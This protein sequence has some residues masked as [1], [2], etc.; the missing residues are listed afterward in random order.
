M[1]ILQKL[2]TKEELSRTGVLGLNDE[3]FSLYVNALLEEEKKDILIVTSTLYEANKLNNYLSN[4]TKDSYLFPMDEFF[5]SESEAHSPD[6]KITRLETLNRTFDDLPKI[7]VTHLNGYLRFLPKKDVYKRSILRIKKGDSF[8]RDDLSSKLFNLGY[9][10]ETLVTKTGEV[11]IRGFVI[12]IFPLEYNSPI[13]IEFFG[14]EIDSIRTFDEESQKSIEELE[15]VIIYPNTE[16]ILENSDKDYS[17]YK[18]KYLR[19]ESGKKVD[20]IY[21]YLKDPIVIFKDYVQIESNYKMLFEQIIEYKYNKDTDYDDNYMFY[22]EDINYKEYK[23]YNTID[24]IFR[25]KNIDYVNFNIEEISSF[26]E[27]IELINDYLK[28]KLIEEKTII[29]ALK[30]HQAMNFVKYLEVNYI[31]TDVTKIVE[32]KINI[33]K[34]PLNEGFIYKDIIVLTNKELFNKTNHI[35]YKTNF[36]YSTKI[37]NTNSLN[38]GDYVV[39]FHYGI[40]VY[41]GIKTI[42]KAGKLKDYLEILYQKKEN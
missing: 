32:G 23:Y 16:F 38:V 4:Y 41:N 8:E 42:T 37:K 6:L 13:R 27:D 17:N 14:D 31:F 20:S 12:D 35:K 29:I 24:N 21:N 33:V 3:F 39:H 1:N 22:L 19:K 26:K 7:I 36:K 9:K 11:G 28:K 40:G 2:I 5:T 10:R 15:E 25:E 30:E 18:Q 34:I